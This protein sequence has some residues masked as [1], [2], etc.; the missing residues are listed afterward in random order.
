[1]QFHHLVLHLCKIIRKLFDPF[2]LVPRDNPAHLSF[3]EK[4]KILQDLTNDI[5]EFRACIPRNLRMD[6]MDTQIHEEYRQQTVFLELLINYT[7]ILAH[8]PL[9]GYRESPHNIAEPLEQIFMSRQQLSREAS[10]KASLE[11]CSMATNHLDKHLSLTILLVLSAWGIYTSVAEIIALHALQSQDDHNDATNAFNQLNS[12][13]QFLERLQPRSSLV[14]QDCS[15][16]R[17][18][19]WVVRA[20]LSRKSRSSP[21]PASEIELLKGGES[22]IDGPHQTEHLDEELSHGQTNTSESDNIDI[23]W[24]HSFIGHGYGELGNLECYNSEFMD[25]DPSAWAD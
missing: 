12:M 11:I 5:H 15:I 4:W 20:K 7:V 2:Y 24:L 19:I 6:K 8:R 1:M 23:Q 17:R 22:F 3:R 18:L 14:G 10:L 21:N 9:A 25:F 13:L 16:L